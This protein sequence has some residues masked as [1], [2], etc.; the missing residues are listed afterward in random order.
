[1]TTTLDRQLRRGHIA[2][3]LFF[4]TNGAVFASLI[5]RYPEL[6][7]ALDMSA[8]VYGIVLAMNPVG[9]MVAGMAAAV[10]IRRFGSA[11]VAAV[12][13]SG[14]AIGIA[15]AAWSPN[16]LLMATSFFVAGMMDAIT[17][18]AQNANA[19]RVQQR[20]GRSIINSMHAL[21]SAGAVTGG[22]LAA[23][24]IALGVPVRFHILV[25]SVVFAGMAF[26]ALRWALPGPESE[27]GPTGEI[28]IAKAAGGVTTKVV[29]LIVALLLVAIG[30]GLVEEVAFSWASLY[31]SDEVGAPAAL[32]AAGFIGLVSAQFVGR[33]VSDRFVDRFGAR[34]VIIVAGVL[35]A[36]GIG[37]AIAVPTVW[38]VCIG[39][40]MAGFGCAPTIPLAMQEADR[41]PGL[42][43]GVGLTIVTWLMRLAFLVAPPLV[44][45]IA[46]ASSIR[47]G[48]TVSLTGGLVVLALSFVMPRLRQRR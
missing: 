13:T 12:A 43:A 3:A 32:A 33:M 39:L 22:V 6:K 2:A 16:I 27:A 37:L 47:V 30:G 24:A 1:M 46:D 15:A 35:I 10:L 45:A 29:F 31:L 26:V 8:T 20:R 4:F 11:R 38:G 17:D 44:G 28:R 7:V 5:P 25:T 48:L 19:L 14:L 34:A 21:W 23:G 18:V 40:A 41:V 42:R 9:A 36:S